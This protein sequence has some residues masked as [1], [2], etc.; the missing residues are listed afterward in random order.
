MH[1]FIAHIYAFICSYI[2]FRKQFYQKKNFIF[3]IQNYTFIK[4]LY[5]LATRHL[6]KV[7]KTKHKISRLYENWKS[8]ILSTIIKS[9]NEFL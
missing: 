9:L 1:V 7:L 6:L 2:I 5:T 8:T 4:V 3:Y